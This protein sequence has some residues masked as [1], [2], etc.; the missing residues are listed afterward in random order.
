M[1]AESG[2]WH[3]SVQAP[4]FFAL[5]FLQ[6]YRFYPKL[7]R[8]LLDSPGV[9]VAKNQPDSRSWKRMP[10]QWLQLNI[11]RIRMCTSRKWTHVQIQKDFVDFMA[12]LYVWKCGE[13]D[14]EILSF[15]FRASVGCFTK[16]LHALRIHQGPLELT[17]CPAK[18][19]YILL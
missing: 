8:I 16:H 6:L 19:F 9:G 2:W 17:L 5:H 1:L 7:R 10:S 12:V 18:D 13:V 4:A 15:T 11:P 14:F 3:C